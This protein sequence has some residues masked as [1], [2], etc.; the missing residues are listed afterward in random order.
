MGKSSPP[1]EKG[2]TGGI[3]GTAFFNSWHKKG[4]IFV[5]NCSF[6]N[7]LGFSLKKKGINSS[8]YIRARTISQ[9]I[10]FADLMIR[11]KK[12]R[13]GNHEP[14]DPILQKSPGKEAHED[15]DRSVVVIRKNRGR[16]PHF[17]IA[18]K[19]ISPS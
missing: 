9:G 11:A 3:S 12:Q 6:S 15:P 5:Q 16:F 7:G 8:C 13:G 2:R 10:H 19:I 14:A 4:F 1:F 18:G 17:R